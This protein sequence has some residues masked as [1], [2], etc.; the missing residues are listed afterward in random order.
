[1]AEGFPIPVRQLV[2]TLRRLFAAQGDAELARLLGAA[3]AD[4]LETGYDSLDGGT[5]YYS[6]RLELPIAEYAA[7]EAALTDVEQTVAA[8][9]RTATRGTGKDV[10][11]DVLIRPVFDERWGRSG[12]ADAPAT[13]GRDPG[14]RLWET[15]MFRLFLS[16]IA[17][18]RA[19]VATLKINL[20]TYGI[21]A[22]VAHEDIEPNL[23]WQDE[24]ELALRSMDAMAALLT[25]HFHESKWTDQEIGVALG[26]GVLIVPVRLP[27]TPYGFIARTQ[28]L[29]GNLEK[30]PQLAERLVDV[31]LAQPRTSQR[32][33]GA[34]LTGLELAGSFAAAKAVAA[35]VVSLVPFAPDEVARIEHALDTNGQVSDAFGVPERLRAAL[36]G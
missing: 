28:A 22:F 4:I 14:D 1:M 10:L 31:L 26:R 30:T 35:K 27:L 2:A 34:L 32:M 33:R 9:A 36:R 29:P 18:H 23:P 20:R 13:G 15:A 19:A 3:R 25:E 21:S 12:E 17:E 11:T 5:T 16:H 7:L 24:I 6:L 8:K